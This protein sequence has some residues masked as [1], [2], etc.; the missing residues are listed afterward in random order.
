MQGHVLFT[1]DFSGHRLPLVCSRAFKVVKSRNI[2]KAIKCRP[3]RGA[4]WRQ[5]RCP[6][7]GGE[8]TPGCAF[9]LHMLGSSWI[10]LLG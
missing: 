2:Y 4:C 5:G 7:G 3:P 8:G 6:V 10:F 1:L 9:A